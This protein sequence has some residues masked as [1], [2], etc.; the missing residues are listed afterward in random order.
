[1]QIPISKF[2]DLRYSVAEIIREMEHLEQ[3]SILQIQDW[4][5]YYLTM[6]HSLLIK[7]WSKRCLHITFLYKYGIN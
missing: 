6:V 5:E 3:R 1:M 7:L 4:I 2:H